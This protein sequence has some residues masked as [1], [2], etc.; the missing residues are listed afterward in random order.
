M[1][2]A[3]VEAANVLCRIIEAGGKILLCGN[4]GSA[5][6]A[7]H[8]A[9]EFTCRLRASMQRP[10][11]AAV[12]LTTDTSFLTACANDFGFDTVFARLTE[13]LGRPGDA[14]IAISTSGDSPNVVRGVSCARDKGIFTI[15]LLGG[16][17]GQLGSLVDLPIVVP[18]QS[19]ACIQECHIAIGHILCELIEEI[20]YGFLRSG[21]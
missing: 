7:Q 4:G 21:G 12:A 10:G 13:V 9:A 3:V 18:S 1:V 11:I 19:T 2:G 15:G 17:G 6:D 14:L 20:L 16:N 8:I 5:A